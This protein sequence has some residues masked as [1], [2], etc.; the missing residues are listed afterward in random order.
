MSHLELSIPQSLGTLV[1]CVSHSL[2]QAERCL[3]TVGLI[4]TVSGEKVAFEF[5]LLARIK[6]GQKEETVCAKAQRRQG[7]Q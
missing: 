7:T 5:I 4:L 3:M 1:G 6:D 2:L